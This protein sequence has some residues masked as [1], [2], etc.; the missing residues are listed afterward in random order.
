MFGSR[1]NGNTPGEDRLNTSTGAEGQNRP[2]ASLEKME[3]K[4]E[5]LSRLFRRKDTEEEP[6]SLYEPEME[7]VTEK[8]LPESS[9]R[10]KG[11]RR[12]PDSRSRSEMTGRQ[13]PRTRRRSGRFCQSAKGTTRTDRMPGQTAARPKAGGWDAFSTKRERSR[14]T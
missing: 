2:S 8:E 10:K 6:V 11:S 7:F 13:K 9:R 12:V 14:T 4:K 3:G 5:K 1:K